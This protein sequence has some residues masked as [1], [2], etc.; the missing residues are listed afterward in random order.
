MKIIITVSIAAVV[1]F[2]LA[3]LLTVLIMKLS[4]EGANMSVKKRVFF[5]VGVGLLFF[6]A[7]GFFYFGIYYHA[8]KPALE[9]MLGN[10]TVKVEQ[11]KEGY[12]FDGPGE[13][14]ALIMY[15]GA[16][17]DERAYA[18]LLLKI[19]EQGVDCYMVAMPLHMAFTDKFAAIRIADQALYKSYYICGH[20]LG[21][22]MAGVCLSRAPEKFAG[23][24]ML[25]SYP[26]QKL[27]DDY[28]YLSFM[29]SEDHVVKMA[30]YDKNK[31]NWPSGGREII[32]EGGNHSGYGDYGEQ[33]GD[34]V[35]SM[36]RDEQ[37]SFVANTIVE[38]IA[39]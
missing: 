28:K 30:V 39:K 27:S 16:K 38:E 1:T 7:G 23:A 22:A 15:P 18:N 11:I 6:V 13:D 9:A 31:V 2:G 37:Q 10:D 21:G 14:T 32:I 24:F 34:G 29:G 20:S 25:A 8:D 3:L 26:S 12:L 19:A 17:V 5:T 33:K 36:S 4:N 35:A